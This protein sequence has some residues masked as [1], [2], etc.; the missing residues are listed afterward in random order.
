MARFRQWHLSGWPAIL[1]APVA[2]PIILLIVLAERLFGLRT[3]ANLTARDVE[4]YLQ[5]FLNESGGDWDW[6]DFTSVPI[7]DP[8]LERIREEAANLDLPL[9]EDGLSKLRC[10]LEQV[11]AM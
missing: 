1:L 11:R 6:D 3:T 5:D 9:T 10:L 7:T 2:I 8:T 4:G